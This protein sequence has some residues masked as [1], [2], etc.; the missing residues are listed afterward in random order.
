MIKVEFVKL[1]ERA[2]LPTKHHASDAGVDLS[3]IE[4]I[5]IYPGDSVIAGT[6]I[7][8][9]TDE[10]IVMLVKS[11][12]GLAFNYGVEASNAGVIDSDYRG[13]IK[14]KLYNTSEKP[15]TLLA[16]MRIAQ[17]VI[18]AIPKIEI[19]TISDGERGDKGFGSS[20]SIFTKEELSK[21][22]GELRYDSLTEE[23]VTPEGARF[24][25]YKLKRYHKLRGT[26]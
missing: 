18:L 5:K 4:E 14:V 17:G 26:R 24:S 1:D 19:T 15:M 22:R 3:L 13:E 8:W 9:V 10:S 7:G 20:D 11:R 16:G 2:V 23:Y 25:K 21:L 12:S 6:G